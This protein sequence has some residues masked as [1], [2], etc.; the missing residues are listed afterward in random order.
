VKEQKRE[1]GP[2][3]GGLCK[4][5]SCYKCVRTAVLYVKVPNAHCTWI[6]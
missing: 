6:T 2:G 3:E 1:R 5:V 4:M